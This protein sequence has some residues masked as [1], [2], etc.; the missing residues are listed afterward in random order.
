MFIKNLWD[1]ILALFKVK[2]QTPSQQYASNEMYNNNYEDVRRINY[3]AIF[4]G[5]L[6]NYVANESTITIE[7]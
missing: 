6:S 2:T 4:A 1:K 3:N 5:K 7:E